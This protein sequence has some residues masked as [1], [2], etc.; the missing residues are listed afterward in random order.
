MEIAA[1]IRDRLADVPDPELGISVVELGMI[2]E[3]S[4]DDAGDVVVRVA[5]TTAGCPLRAKLTRDVREAARGVAGVRSVRVA[6]GEMD[7]E[8]RRSA[9]ERA[10][11][12]AQERQAVTTVAP[13]VPV[14]AIASGKGGVGKSTVAANLA[15]ALARL[16]HVVGV[17]D[18][19]VWG[20]SLARLLGVEGPV[21][22]VAGRMRPVRRPVG[23]G[24]LRVLAMG[25]LAQ[26]ERALAWRGLVVQK[27]VAQFLE[28]ADWSGIDYL[29]VDT[30]P[31][32]GDVPMTLARLLP[33]LGVVLVTTPSRAATGVAA[34]TADF[35]R[36]HHLRL[37]G[38]VENMAPATS[39]SGE[40]FAPFGRD[41]GRELAESLGVELLASIPLDHALAQA[42]DEG[43]PLALEGDG[44]A[45]GALARRLR[46]DVAP[47]AGQAGC[48]ARLL[49]ALAR[50]VAG[51]GAPGAF[52][53]ELR[54][55]SS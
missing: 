7:A 53:G 6:F 55:Q 29:V 40:E 4:V 33:R 19:D 51:D 18:A 34:R 2:D 50:A 44:G 24:E 28:D 1:Q 32:T 10:R 15:V 12:A 11:R 38:V 39:A 9:L 35:A 13:S 3:V 20:F 5:L 46:D 36:G 31:G 52:P 45:F 48:S 26:E 42:G 25:L 54:G 41:G 37:L 16:G 23:P 8:A 14:L 27:A 21:E 17:L 47:P 49:D 22:A 30:P 43:R